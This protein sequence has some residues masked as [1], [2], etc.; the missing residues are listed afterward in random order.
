ML[1]ETDYY[2]ESH[3]TLALPRLARGETATVE[4]VGISLW[5]MNSI[6][7]A[8]RGSG[9]RA[10]SGSELFG[11]IL[12]IRD[13]AGSILLRAFSPQQLAREAESTAP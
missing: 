7:R 9:T 4:G 6:S 11:L 2:R 1:T 12:T 8:S 10:Y 13:G 5:R 3:E